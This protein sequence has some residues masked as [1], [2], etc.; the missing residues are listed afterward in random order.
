MIVSVCWGRLERVCVCPRVIC[1][2]LLLGGRSF[3]PLS[4]FDD[5]AVSCVQIANE[6]SNKH[7]L[8]RLVSD[9]LLL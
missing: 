3:V 4:M 7:R 5:L 6:G 1:V 8:L 2:R 9:F